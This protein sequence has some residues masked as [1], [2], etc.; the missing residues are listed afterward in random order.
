MIGS[1]DHRIITDGEF[2]W[3]GEVYYDDEGTITGFTNAKENL[4][5][6]A[7]FDEEL[8]PEGTNEAEIRKDF[9]LIAT[10]FTKPTLRIPP[11]FVERA[12]P[13]YWRDVQVEDWHGKAVRCE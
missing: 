12:R 7:V 3:I 2:I 8:N 10:A 5:A 6:L 1:W 4:L 13:D 11:C 9:D